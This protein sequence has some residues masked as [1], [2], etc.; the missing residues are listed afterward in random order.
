MGTFAECVLVRHEVRGAGTWTAGAAVTWRI[1]MR[2]GKS[3]VL[4]LR[5][6]HLSALTRLREL[7]FCD[8]AKLS[9]TH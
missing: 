9:G 1:G 2:I 8:V 5:R 7:N 6:L 4:D 3:T